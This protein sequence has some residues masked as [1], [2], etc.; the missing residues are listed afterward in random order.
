MHQCMN[1]VDLID[2]CFFIYEADILNIAPGKYKSIITH[3][4]ITV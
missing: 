4:Y 1:F 3:S 2:R